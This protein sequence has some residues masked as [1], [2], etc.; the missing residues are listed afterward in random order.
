MRSIAI[1][2][3]CLLFAVPSFAQT[4]VVSGVL[5]AFNQY[6][7]ANVEVTAQ[8]SKTSVLTDSLG[9]FK[10]V[11]KE[12]DVIKIKPEAF[13]SESR[14]INKGEVEETIRINL[15]FMDSNKNR[16]LAVANGYL[17]EDE[18]TYAVSHLLQENNEY[19]NFSNI[20]ELLRGRFP[21]VHVDGTSGRYVVY[22]R[23]NHS[24]NASNEVLW[25]VDGTA[26]ASV[27]GLHPCNISSISVIKDGLAAAYG[28]RGSNGVILVETKK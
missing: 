7:V 26:G 18:L 22:I 16:E 12:K 21:G 2:A 8:K 24:V 9:M 15:V 23:E 19:C 14:T 10:I 4:K 25:V 27:D 11:C 1:L 3:M 6:P 17:K 5:T 28:T 20:Y 13:K